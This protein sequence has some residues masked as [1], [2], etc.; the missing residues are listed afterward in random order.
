MRTRN[1]YRI[2]RKFYQIPNK[3]KVLDSDDD[4]MLNLE[5]RS[6]ECSDSSR[7]ESSE[8]EHPGSAPESESKEECT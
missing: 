1:Y 2:V 4:A 5:D 3:R 7:D 6:H 8:D